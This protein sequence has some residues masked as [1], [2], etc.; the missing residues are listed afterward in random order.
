MPLSPNAMLKGDFSEYLD[1]LE[2]RA[3]G[4]RRYSKGETILGQADDWGRLHFFVLSGTVGVYYASED[5]D[6]G[7]SNARGVGTIFP[8]YSSY[9]MVSTQYT[10]RAVA[11]EP[12]EC[13]VIDGNVLR[14]TME[15]YPGMAFT[16]IDAHMRYA[17]YLVYTIEGLMFESLE[18]RVC[19]YL[20]L[21]ANSANLVYA[22]HDDIAHAV[23]S[24]REA[25]SRML[26]RLKS[27][28]ILESK[29]GVVRIEAKSDLLGRASYLARISGS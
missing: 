28:G 8:L 26:S 5:G 15:D 24:S 21:N 1:I 9:G 29:R 13:L 11:E 18:T 17:S 23:G 2:S 14:R 16:M 3:C 6:V 22:T 4:K 10:M 12:T 20:L 27:E 19:D 25:V 7:F